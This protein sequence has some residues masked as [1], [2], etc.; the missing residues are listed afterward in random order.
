MPFLEWEKTEAQNCT[1]VPCRTLPQATSCSYLGPGH[2]CFTGRRG[3]TGSLLFSGR[4]LPRGL[5]GL[6]VPGPLLQK[7]GGVGGLGPEINPYSHQLLCA[8]TPV[9]SLPWGTCVLMRQPDAVHSTRTAVRLAS[10]LPELLPWVWTCTRL[11]ASVARPLCKKKSSWLSR[12][13]IVAA[14]LRS[15]VGVPEKAWTPR[16]GM[17]LLPRGDSGSAKDVEGDR[18]GQPA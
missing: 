11:W 3:P 8:H 14:A 1:D 9:P 2:R 16:S 4:G 17:E 5:P 13:L 10:H 6:G 7:G 15:W 12:T 18:K